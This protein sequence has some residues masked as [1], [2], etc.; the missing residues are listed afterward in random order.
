[1]FCA[2]DWQ[3]ASLALGHRSK[4]VQHHQQLLAARQERANSKTDA[5]GDK[6]STE[7]PALP[8]GQQ[9]ALQAG[10]GISLRQELQLQAAE[11]CAALAKSAADAVDSV[12]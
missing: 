3:A 8:D 2:G 4:D 7:G 11:R 6:D 1:M 5:A 9:Q 12:R 10:S